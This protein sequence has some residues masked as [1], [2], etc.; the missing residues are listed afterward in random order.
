VAPLLRKPVAHGAKQ[1]GCPVPAVAPQVWTQ[2]LPTLSALAKHGW[3]LP[4]QA[5]AQ[6]SAAA[7]GAGQLVPQSARLAMHAVR[8]ARNERRHAT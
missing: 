8:A 6:E 7:D 3:A 1:P 2:V 4:L 5:L